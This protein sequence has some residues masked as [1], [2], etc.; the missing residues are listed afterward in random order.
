[1]TDR[2]VRQID[3]HGI[4]K[5]D[6]RLFSEFC[7]ERNIVLLG[8]PGAGKT[9]L[10]SHFSNSCGGIF[11]TARNF[12]I[13]DPSTF[14]GANYL[15]IDALD[16]KRSGRG[17]DSTIDQIATRLAQLEP[18][19]VRLACRAAD[20]LGDYDLSA[21]KA[22]LPTQNEIKVLALERLSVVEQQDILISLGENDPESFLNAAANRGLTSMCENPQTLKML[23]EQVGTRGWPATRR[24][25]FANSIEL[26]VCE[27]NLVHKRQTSMDFTNE[28]R[29]QAAGAACALRLISDID[30][31][32]L[33][34]ISEDDNCP[35]YC[36]LSLAPRDRLLSVLS[37]RL[38]V[39]DHS[40]EA[41][42]YLHRTLA[43][44][45]AAGWIADQVRNGLPYGRVK[46]LVTYEGIPTTELRGLTAWLA[47]HLQEHAVELIDAD[48]FGVMTYGDPASFSQGTRLHLIR[49]LALLAERDPWFRAGHWDASVTG[50]GQPDL[51]PHFREIL[52]DVN[53]SHSLRSIILDAILEGCL[54]GEMLDILSDLAQNSTAETSERTSAINALVQAGKPGGNALLNVYPRLSNSKNDLYVRSRI[55]RA[56]YG[57]GIGPRDIASLLEDALGLN[58][59]LSLNVFW[60]LDEVIPDCDIVSILDIFDSPDER[61]YDELHRVNISNVVEVLET[62]ICRVI[63]GDS[64]PGPDVVIGWLD[65]RKRLGHH[66]HRQSND[67]LR[68]AL[69]QNRTLLIAVTEHYFTSCAASVEAWNLLRQFETLM[70]G[71]ADWSIS[72]KSVCSAVQNADPTLRPFYFETA[73]MLSLQVGPSALAEFDLL[74]SMREETEFGEVVD[75]C[76]ICEVPNWRVE[77]SERQRRRNIEKQT[78]RE[79]DREAF[80]DSSN[81]IME[82]CHLGWM[83]YLGLIYFSRFSDLDAS[84]SPRQRLNGVFGE[85]RAEKALMGIEK[86][87]IEGQF[88]SVE[89]ILSLDLQGKYQKPWYAF[90]AGLCEYH[91]KGMSLDLLDDQRLVSALIIDRLHPTES[92]QG[93][94]RS[95]RHHAWK[96]ELLVRRPSFVAQ[97]YEQ[98]A[99]H[100]LNAGNEYVAG[101]Y[102]LVG[103]EE[104]FGVRSGHVIQLLRDFPLCSRNTLEILMQAAFSDAPCEL[105]ELIPSSCNAA[106]KSGSI[107]AWA[108]WQA[109]GLLLEVPGCLENIRQSD[110]AHAESLVRAMRYAFRSHRKPS[111]HITRETAESIDKF[112][113]QFVGSRVPYT[114]HPD[115]GWRGDDNPWDASEFV[116]ARINKLATSSTTESMEALELLIKNDSLLSYRQYLLHALA[117]QRILRADANFKRPTWID[118]QRCVK[119]GAPA[120]IADL[121]ALALI[122]VKDIRSRIVGANTDPYKQFWNVDSRGKIQSP[123]PEEDCRD[124]F[125]EMLRP[126]L[127]RVGVRAEPEGHMASDKRADIC[128]FSGTMKLSIEL[129]RD[130]HPEIWTAAE[131]QLDRFY[132]R[133]PESQGYGVYGVF[134]FGDKR[135][136]TMPNPPNGL[137]RPV[138]AEDL[139]TALRNEVPDRVRQKIQIF[140]LDVS[141]Y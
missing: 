136:R 111:G 48:P 112:V 34:E 78:S 126:L 102:E 20:W 46:A 89:V 23:W 56:I 100:K 84:V 16:E 123:K 38:F 8:D 64:I 109:F 131:Q 86:F 132:T 27:H 110:N 58:E 137:L 32:S 99:R 117:S 79:R 87:A 105:R 119:G 116:V 127:N 97:A 106:A 94:E 95:E 7:D 140:V 114:K 134:W 59:E 69:I 31:V 21:L 104:L 29:L 24:E 37:S 68:N 115:G 17:F 42:D 139:E 44:F 13:R 93:N 67:C 51:I 53:H 2:L 63:G 4:V 80:D 91:E 41:V 9:H 66:Y 83:G 85:G 25:L 47:V 43:E 76:V 90:M 10:F 108:L 130:Y 138:S 118:V 52:S 62:L 12:L 70:V 26:L 30:G 22:A 71:A 39:A 72:L 55:V 128:L 107:D 92:T 101:L 74:L 121:Q 35:S 49:A 135:T 5:A 60:K 3:Q 45:T 18:C 28:G 1:M 81:A 77:D 141:G 125:V 50:L 133:D 54:A 122:H 14:R 96:S 98:L 6:R 88:P 129:K 57:N 103:K 36:D 82:G 113:I 120:N 75:R 11:L 33:L 61:S 15:F 124:A 73:L 40:L 65:K 19:H